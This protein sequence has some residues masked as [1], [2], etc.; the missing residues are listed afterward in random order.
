[1]DYK[2]IFELSGSLMYTLSGLSLNRIEASTEEIIA[3]LNKHL[4]NIVSLDKTQTGI[5]D[6]FLS[7]K[8]GKLY[9]IKS[10]LGDS[11]LVLSEPDDNILWIAGP[12]LDDSDSIENLI[13]EYHVKNKTPLS[14]ELLKHY[15]N[16]LPIVSTEKLLLVG[17]TIAR[18]L[19]NIDTSDLS[20]Q[21]LTTSDNEIPNLID[22]Y[23]LLLPMRIM[24][25]R[26][27]YSTALFAAVSEGDFNT[28]ISLYNSLT[29]DIASIQRNKNPIRNAQ[30]LCII[31]NSLLRH[32][33][34]DRG[35]HPYLLNKLS[36]EIGLKIEQVRT[37]SQ[38]EHLGVQILNDYCQLAAKHHYSGNNQLIREA[39][40]YVCTN[41]SDTITVQDTARLLNVNPDYFSHLFSKE[42]GKTFISFVNERR[43]SQALRLLTGTNMMIG[44]IA[45][46]VGYGN[47]NY[48]SVQFQK[49]YG[50]TPKQYRQQNKPKK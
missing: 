26:Y 21:Y 8:A 20:L 39:V 38:L 14:A 34:Q 49:I 5:I 1:M 43:C 7:V 44:Q 15:Y 6:L 10:S 3:Y 41:I 35:I 31:M 4:Y 36:N 25:K 13:G 46:Q 24:E 19:Y 23:E 16:Q 30:N 32:T 47:T 48:F 27:D 11:F 33:V 45:L 28:A 12:C 29:S 50:C 37:F 17:R 2:E 9:L 22:D 40:T 18:F 42:T